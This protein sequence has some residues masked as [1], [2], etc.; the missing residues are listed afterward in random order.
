VTE[1]GE[2][3]PTEPSG[4][5]PGE[6]EGGLEALIRRAG[7]HG[8]GPAPVDKWDP[9]YRGDIDMRIASDG[10][11]FYMGTKI[12]REALVRLFSTVLRKDS[13]GK[14][15]LVTPVERL[16]I[17]VDDAPFV[18]VEMHA[19]GEGREQVLTLRT[20]VGEV[21]EAGPEHPLRFE[22]EEGTGGLKPYIHVRGRLEALLLRPLLYELAE[23]GV[24]EEFDGTRWF[25]VWSNGVFYK[26]IPSD[27]LERL[28]K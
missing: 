11:W 26:A 21:I 14:H 4:G 24:D 8:R 23:F 15:Y 25:G 3:P 27:E 6:I 7:E 13:D 20:N 2:I 5:S 28:A 18:A 9:D 22:D 16:G 1:T 10:T 19:S 12:E 17:V